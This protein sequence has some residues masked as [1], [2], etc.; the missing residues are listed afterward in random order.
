MS[1]KEINVSSADVISI[2]NEAMEVIEQYSETCESIYN[3]RKQAGLE[4]DEQESDKYKVYDVLHGTRKAI[5]HAYHYKKIY[6]AWDPCFSKKPPTV[7]YKT[8]IQALLDAANLSE[9]ITMNGNNVQKLVK[10]KKDNLIK[11]IEFWI[12]NEP[13][14]NSLFKDSDFTVQEEVK[15]S[16]VTKE[17]TNT[18]TEAPKP[19]DT[20]SEGY[21]I[22][23]SL[24]ISTN[25]LMI[26]GAVVLVLVSILAGYLSL[27]V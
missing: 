26:L 14:H 24:K 5:V 19:E 13:V 16:E 27:G 21:D 4:F 8:D 7:E 3:K 10:F 11:E 25:E 23:A 17:I 6:A 20:N 2:C 1:Y 22:S 18:E 9:F 15:E 12:K